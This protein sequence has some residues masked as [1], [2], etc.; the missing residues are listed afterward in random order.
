MSGA[1][2]IMKLQIIVGS[3]RPGRLARPVADWAAEA[4]EKHGGFE[5]ELVDLVDYGLPLLDEPGPPRMGRYEH[6]HTRRWSAKIKEADA[7]VFVTPEYNYGPSVSLLN[8]VDYLHNEWLYAPVGFVSYGGIAGGLRSVQVMKQVVTTVRMMPIPEGVAIPFVMQH[9]KA[10]VFDP[11]PP[12]TGSV[13]PMLTELARWANVLRPLRTAPPPP[14]P[15]L[16]GPATA[17]PGSAPAPGPPG[18]DTGPSRTS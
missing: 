4:A 17:P 11:P 1:E 15:P 9:V 16:P 7:F 18:A 2:D 13:A 14:P 10:G 5:V 6:E 12:V 8:A 3:T